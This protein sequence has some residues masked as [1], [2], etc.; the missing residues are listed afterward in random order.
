MLP[1]DRALRGLASTLTPPLSADG[2][3]LIDR[4]K[5]GVD[6]DED[7]DGVAAGSM[8]DSSL[9]GWN[10]EAH[11]AGDCGAKAEAAEL[12][13]VMGRATVSAAA[14]PLAASFRSSEGDSRGGV[15]AVG[16][17]V[18]VALRGTSVKSDSELAAGGGRGGPG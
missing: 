4:E 14:R 1:L 7:E 18:P 5:A 10:H 12:E 8:D 2:D 6:E 11:L 9:G 13:A 3:V 15:L 17:V 16:G